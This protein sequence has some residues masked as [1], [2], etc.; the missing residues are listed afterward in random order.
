[1]TLKVRFTQKWYF[2]HHFLTLKSFQDCMTLFLLWNTKEDVLKNVYNQ[3]TLVTIDLQYMEKKQISKDPPPATRMEKYLDMDNPSC[4]SVV[5][6]K[7]LIVVK[8]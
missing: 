7:W 8:M 2:C 6:Q 5:N 3:T 1:M 4:R